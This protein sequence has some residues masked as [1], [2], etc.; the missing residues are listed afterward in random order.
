MLDTTSVTPPRAPKQGNSNRTHLTRWEKEKAAAGSADAFDHPNDPKFIGPWIIGETIG[1]GASG[2]VKIARHRLTGMFAAVKIL[3]YGLWNISSSKKAEKHRVSVE[4]EIVLMKLMEHPNIMRLYDVWEGKGNLYLILEWIEGGELFDL[5]VDRGCLP[6][7]QALTYFKQLI[8]GLSYCHAF[9]IAHRDLKP[10]N[11]LIH[12]SNSH[13]VKIADWGMAAFQTPYAHLETSCGSPHYASPEVIRGEQYDGAK[14]DIWSVGVVLYALLAGRLP[15]DDPDVPRLLGKVR[16]G[17]FVIPSR[18]HADVADLIRRMLVVDPEERI[19]MADILEH[20]FLKHDT[21]GIYYIPPPSISN[22][23][24]ALK[25]E[26]D[27]DPDIFISLRILYGKH[28]TGDAIRKDLFSRKPTRAKAFYFL[29][30]KFRDRRNDDLDINDLQLDQGKDDNDIFGPLTDLRPYQPSRARI[31]TFQTLSSPALPSSS[32]Q[33]PPRYHHTRTKSSPPYHSSPP[34]LQSRLPVM[35]NRHTKPSQYKVQDISTKSN[36]HSSEAT[37]VAS[38]VLD[39]AAPTHATRVE[40]RVKK[41]K[42]VTS[43][44]PDDNISV[45]PRPRRRESA[46]DPPRTGI[47]VDFSNRHSPQQK[48]TATATRRI[49]NKKI[50]QVRALSACESSLHEPFVPLKAPR[51]RHPEAQLEMEELVKRM[52]ALC[53]RDA[54]RTRRRNQV[55]P[56]EHSPTNETPDISEGKYPKAGRQERMSD[57]K[58]NVAVKV[59]VNEFGRR[60]PNL[61][62][63][64][65]TT[66]GTSNDDSK[67]SRT[68]RSLIKRLKFPDF[69]NSW[70]SA[71]TTSDGP[72]SS[73]HSE[74][75]PTPSTSKHEVKRLLNRLGTNVAEDLFNGNILKCKLDDDAEKVGFTLPRRYIKFRVEFHAHK[76]LGA[77][78]Y[79][80]NTN[81]YRLSTSRQSGFTSTITFIPEKGSLSSFKAVCEKIQDEWRFNVP[82]IVDPDVEMGRV[83][84]N[85]ITTMEGECDF[86]IVE[87]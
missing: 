83:R 4:R 49:A 75:S 16:S 63:R 76:R 14:A 39:S 3:P 29:L 27:I 54:E 62:R 34:F 37:L 22:L 21:P 32:Q 79:S 56:A 25:T 30:L 81:G 67:R 72:I 87:H 9:S 1:K 28:A 51:L 38:R 65:S 64:G 43:S 77:S 84:S 68:D 15:F 17:R 10:E 36:D 47:T 40:K 6:H 35:I 57:E 73:V 86:M 60:V 11:I 48:T 66:T 74:S 50:S 26:K 80:V 18:I 41:E 53:L 52:N 20:P 55:S 85:D 69:E 13:Y 61:F 7:A 59:L 44:Q 58:E 19:S 70:I 78:E 46:P 31:F 33:C 8:Y 23:E 2:R 71:N 12:G 45:R 24:L 5:I 82:S 42:P